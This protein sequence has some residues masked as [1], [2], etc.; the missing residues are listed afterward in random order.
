MKI[1]FTG[2]LSILFIGLKLAGFIS[3]SW[4]WVLSPIWISLILWIVIVCVVLVL[5]ANPAPRPY[6]WR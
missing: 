5:A 3:W 4:L 1:G 2:L 6:T